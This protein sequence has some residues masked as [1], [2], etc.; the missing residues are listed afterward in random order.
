MV[1]GESNYPPIREAEWGAISH[2]AAVT[3]VLNLNGKSALVFFSFPKAERNHSQSH[4]PTAFSS[5]AGIY[6]SCSEGQVERAEVALDGPVGPR[7]GDQIKPKTSKVLAFK[8]H[9]SPCTPLEHKLGPIGTP[10]GS[11]LA[12]T[13]ISKGNILLWTSAASS[14]VLIWCDP[15]LRST[16]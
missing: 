7:G 13:Q 3:W 8:Q 5:V 15:F 10:C 14:G 16:K 6:A 1:T 11:V 9:H 12:G 4:A 2:G